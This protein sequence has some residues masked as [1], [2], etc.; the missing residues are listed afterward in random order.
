[1]C[2]PV[3]LKRWFGIDSLSLVVF[4]LGYLITMPSRFTK[5]GEHGSTY[6]FRTQKRENGEVK[7]GNVKSFS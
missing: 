4:V 3:E 2:L 1:M 6:F 7:E 5:D